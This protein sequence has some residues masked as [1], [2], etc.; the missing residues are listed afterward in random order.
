MN[1]L[2]TSVGS[3][4][5]SHGSER[6]SERY[7]GL[8]NIVK[9]ICFVENQSRKQSTLPQVIFTSI[10][11]C[12]TIR[13]ALRYCTWHLK[14]KWRGV[15]E[16]TLIRG[17]VGLSL[18]Q[19]PSRN[20]GH[21]IFSTQSST[22]AILVIAVSPTICSVGKSPC[23]MLCQKDRAKLFYVLDLCLC[24]MRDVSLSDPENGG[25]C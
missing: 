24:C 18:D 17:G 1:C 8:L 21:H 2:N 10:L 19:G 3:Q 23:E 4:K 7:G 15:A 14:L 25:Y 22:T 6:S 9:C 5:P 13:F 12:E 16:L 20:M 11:Y